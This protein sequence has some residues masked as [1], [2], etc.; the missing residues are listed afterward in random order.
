MKTV[1][2]L[3][4]AAFAESN[5]GRPE[6]LSRQPGFEIGFDSI[7]VFSK[8]TAQLV[9]QVRKWLPSN[10]V[11][12][13]KRK[14]NL[15]RKRRF[16]NLRSRMIKKHGNF[17]AKELV[18]ACRMA[19]VQEGCI[20]FVQCSYDDLLTYKGTPYDLLSGLR[21]LVGPQGTL[22]MPA[23]TTNMWDTPCRPFDVL[24]EPTY[25]GILPE[26]FRREDGVVRSLHPRHSI[27]GLGPHAGELLAGHEECVYADGPDSPFDRIRKLDGAQSVCLGLR[28]GFHSFVHWVEDIEPEKYP[29]PMHE[30]P[31]DCLLRDAN[32][33]EIQRPF[34]RR[35]R[36]QRNQDVLIGKN[37]GPDA[38]RPLQFHGVWL[39]FY[40]WP[41]LAS[42]LLALRDRGIV[43][44]V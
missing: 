19:G 24:R 4:S 34:Y 27:C 3:M 39:C 14:R 8:F 36:R 16:A 11:A 13:V 6:R 26:L 28:P 18:T 17:T 33:K 23:Y 35:P 43:C 22:L 2:A 37:L 7:L 10:T 5:G 15:R 40:T 32:G 1:L 30:G 25:T 38:M 21:E 29:I 31:F 41:A 42:E 9:Q 44:F 20:L 12:W